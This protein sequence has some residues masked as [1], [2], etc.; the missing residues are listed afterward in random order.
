MFIPCV[1]MIAIAILLA[2]M[3]GGDLRHAKG[4]SK[5]RKSF[6]KSAARR[7]SRANGTVIG[8][9]ALSYGERIR[10][11]LVSFEAG[12]ETHTTTGPILDAYRKGAEK[13]LRSGALVLSQ[14]ELG[15]VNAH[16]PEFAAAVKGFKGSEKDILEGG[17]RE[18]YDLDYAGSVLASLYPLGSQVT[19]AYDPE[20]PSWNACVLGLGD[21]TE[22]GNPITK[23]RVRMAWL[24][25]VIEFLGAVVVAEFAVGLLLGTVA[26]V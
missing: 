10:C 7:I 4:L 9:S 12:G 22:V 16:T 21:E 11:P 5:D 15:Y 25:G 24:K 20:H 26:L 14:P 2:L 6:A 3:A 13:Q 17:T 18:W 19:V 8:G 1:L 23:R